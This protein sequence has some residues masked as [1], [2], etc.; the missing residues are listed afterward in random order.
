MPDGQIQG[1]RL[2][3]VNPTNVIFENVA[4]RRISVAR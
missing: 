3:S 2:V 4:G 1:W